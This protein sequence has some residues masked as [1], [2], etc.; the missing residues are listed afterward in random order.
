MLLRDD[1]ENPNDSLRSAAIVELIRGMKDS[2]TLSVFNLLDIPMGGARLSFPIECVILL[3]PWLY[4]LIV[5][6]L[7]T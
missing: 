4:L 3:D 7:G 2:E 1:A 6:D 5:F